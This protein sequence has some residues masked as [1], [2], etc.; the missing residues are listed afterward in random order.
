MCNPEVRGP[1]ERSSWGAGASSS[2]VTRSKKRTALWRFFFWYRQAL[3]ADTFGISM[4]GPAKPALRNSP[5]L[6]GSEF[7]AHSHCGPEGP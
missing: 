2:L 6:R 3:P 7:T 5:P 1:H 4:L